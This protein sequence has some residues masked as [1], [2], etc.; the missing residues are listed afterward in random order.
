MAQNISK[1]NS[2][3]WRFSGWELTTDHYPLDWDQKIC[4][5]VWR[6]D[7]V[8][9]Q[10]SKVD[11]SITVHRRPMILYIILIRISRSCWWR[12]LFV[13]ILNFIFRPMEAIALNSVIILDR[14]TW[15]KVALTDVICSYHTRLLLYRLWNI[16][17]RYPFSAF[18]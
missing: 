6:H 18:W 13:K 9:D 16:Q 5:N 10:T 7:D 11:I 4:P 3:I 14:I 2:D 15:L 17:P 12:Y 8:T 1:S